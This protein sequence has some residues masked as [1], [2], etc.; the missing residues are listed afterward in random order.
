MTRMAKKPPPPAKP[1]R[2]SIESIRWMVRRDMAE[3]L[4]IEEQAFEWPWGEDDFIRCLRERNCIGMVA[5]CTGI[6][7]RDGNGRDVSFSA[8][9]AYMIYELHKTRLH[10]LN[11]AVHPDH[12]RRGIGRQMVERLKGK[13]SPQ[14]RGRITLECRESNL[15]GQLFWK[16][17]GFRAVNVLREFY[18]GGRTT[19]DA[20][21]FQ[22]RL[23]PSA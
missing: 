21:L 20:Y 3:V 10:V 19:E 1:E 7:G 2:S 15:R 13:L 18:D 11:F 9:R 22:Y 6:I 5:E 12:W 17:M 4:A 8:I 23:P 16:A 14:R